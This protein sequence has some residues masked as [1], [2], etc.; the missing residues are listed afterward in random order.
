MPGIGD[1]AGVGNF[2]MKSEKA[3][4]VRKWGEADKTWKGEA[5]KKGETEAF[6]RTSQGK[7][8][9][10][11]S[12]TGPEE[13]QNPATKYGMDRTP[14]MYSPYKMKGSPMHR[15]FGVGDAPGVGSSPT[16]GLFSKFKQAVQGVG[17]A[18]GIEGGKSPE[19]PE[20]VATPEQGLDGG[21]VQ[22]HSH[23]EEG[24]IAAT[25]DQQTLANKAMGFLGGGGTGISATRNPVGPGG[26]PLI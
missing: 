7:S 5:T 19:A 3:K 11:E 15:N 2:D 24:N 12:L 18:L 23:D 21:Q 25:A 9:Y 13:V 14:A 20:E 17:S 16:K 8:R 1:Y 4:N 26:R 6:L 22:E 10:G